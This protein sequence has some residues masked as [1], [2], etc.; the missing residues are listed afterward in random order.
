MYVCKIYI[1]MCI[2]LD[3]TVLFPEDA[4]LGVLASFG[5]LLI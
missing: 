2:A 4:A 3:T 5:S 1:H